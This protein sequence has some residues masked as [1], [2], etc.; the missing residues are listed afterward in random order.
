[1]IHPEKTAVLVL[2]FASFFIVLPLC[3]YYRLIPNAPIPYLLTLALVFR[4][5]LRHDRGFDQSRLVNASAALHRLLPVLLRSAA[6][7]AL[8]GFAVWRLA[9]QLLFSFVRQAPSFWAIVMVFYPLLSV[10]PQEL[11]FRA[12]FFRRYE[13]LFGEGWTMVGASAL[14]FGFVHIAMGNWISVALSTVGGLLFALTYQQS[15]SLLLASV[16]HA[17]FGNFIFTVG[18]GEYFYHG[19]RLA[20]RG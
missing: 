1:L 3:L 16:E 9:P 19:A 4:F 20:G 8:L 11:I 17:I 13:A 14:A 10:Y 18:L 2:E 12:Y 15:R 6:L 7:C 5:V